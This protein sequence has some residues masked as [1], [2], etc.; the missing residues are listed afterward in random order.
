M[1]TEE[2]DYPIHHAARSCNVK[3]LKNVLSHPEVNIDQMTKNGLTALEL[4]CDRITNDNCKDVAKCILQLLKNKATIPTS[5][6]QAMQANYQ[7]IYSTLFDETQRQKIGPN[8]ENKFVLVGVFLKYLRDNSTE[9]VSISQVPMLLKWAIKTKNDNA[10]KQLIEHYKTW[11][12]KEK[13]S[14][15]CMI[16][17]LEEILPKSILT[18]C[19]KVGNYTVLEYLFQ[20]STE[21][22]LKHLLQKRLYGRFVE[23]NLLVLLIHNIDENNP[24]CPFFKCLRLCLNISLIDVDKVD[25]RGRRALDY[26]AIY[27]LKRVQK[28]L[29]EKG[30]YIFGKDKFGESVICKIDQNVLDHYFASRLEE[31]SE[32]RGKEQKLINRMCKTDKWSRSY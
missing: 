4:L 8:I 30:A 22:E 29:L 14:A 2:G 1:V 12:Y 20:N 23:G 21:D 15:D 28:L 17:P 6:S 27:K 10:A 24:D 19:C 31:S 7:E 3:T 25:G 5:I 26:A 32:R 16:D 11:Y 13:L 9:N 18:C